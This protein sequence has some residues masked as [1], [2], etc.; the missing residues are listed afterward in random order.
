MWS[1]KGSKKGETLK[2]YKQMFF[3]PSPSPSFALLVGNCDVIALVENVQQRPRGEM[4]KVMSRAVD[5]D[6]ECV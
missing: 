4:N 6:T 3:V 1:K 2:S 5:N